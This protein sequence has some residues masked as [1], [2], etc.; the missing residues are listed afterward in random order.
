MQPFGLK[1]F[2]PTT[3]LR[4]EIFRPAFLKSNFILQVLSVFPADTPLARFCHID[5]NSVNVE[6]EG[7]REKVMVAIHAARAC[8]VVQGEDLVSK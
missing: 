6:D 2:H 8:I 4:Q 7:L 1:S 5:P 3:T